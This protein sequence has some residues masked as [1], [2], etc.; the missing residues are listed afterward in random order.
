MENVNRNLLIRFS[1]LDGIFWAFYAA[2]VGYISTYLLSCGMSNTVLS[3]MLAVFMLTSFIGAFFWGNLCDRLR[4]NKKIF[5]PA[6]SVA[7]LLSLLIFYFAS[8]NIWISTILYPIFGFIS[9]PLGSNLDAWMLRTFHQNAA[10]YGKARSVGSVGYAVTALVMG[11]LINRFGYQLIPIG[12]LL[13]GGIVLILAALMKE[14]PMEVI[15]KEN[16]KVNPMKLLSIKPYVFMLIIIFFTGLSISPINNLKIIILQSVGG[17]VGIL[18]IDSFLGV[19]VQA[20]FIFSSG[21]LRRLSTNLRLFLVALCVLIPM[22]LTFTATSS[23]MI[24]LGTIINNISYGIM[25]PTTR[26]I[27]EKSVSDDLK[28]T[29]HALS[30]AMYGSFAGIIALLYSGTMMDHFGAKSVALLGMIIMMIPVS[31]SLFTL[32]KNR[33]K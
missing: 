16:H 7:I 1:I 25:L 23:F 4:S 26:E 29:A 31:L 28:N 22:I 12:S 21:M 27:T 2:F 32:M 10:T 11:L 24:I 13:T 19:M 8:R 14:V 3:I 17:D 30:D 33:N 6:F 20:L 18:G 5:I 9:S 15:Q